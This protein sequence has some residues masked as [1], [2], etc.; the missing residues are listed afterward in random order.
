MFDGVCEVGDR[1]EFE[2]DF[3][4]FRTFDSLKSVDTII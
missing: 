2:V 4:C 1:S 3:S